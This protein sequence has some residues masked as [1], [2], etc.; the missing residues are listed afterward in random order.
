MSERKE[1]YCGRSLEKHHD[2]GFWV[3]PKKR[4]LV[5]KRPFFSGLLTLSMRKGYERQQP[6]LNLML[7]LKPKLNEQKRTETN[8]TEQKRKFIL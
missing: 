6:M 8:R 5:K 3:V 4:I 2:F 1:C 7:M